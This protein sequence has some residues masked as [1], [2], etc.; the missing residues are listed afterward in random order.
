[1]TFELP[2][3]PYDYTALEP[4]ID[5]Q[6]MHLHHDMHHKAYVAK[7]NEAMGGEAGDIV[8][9]QRGAKLAPPAIRNNGGGHY[10]HSLFW[11][12]MAPVGTSSAAPHG[13]VLPARALP[14]HHHYCAAQGR[15]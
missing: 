1:M 15:H 10:N 5:A 13:K 2:A 12:W 11:K 6:T 7:L 3:L 8:A 4:Y 14:P 9:V